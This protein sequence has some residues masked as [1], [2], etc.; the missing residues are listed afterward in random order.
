MTPT[1]PVADLDTRFSSE[2]AHATPWSEVADL[3]ESAEIYWLSTVRP[4]GRP[5][6][7]PLIAVWNDGALYFCTGPTER[8]AK[9]LVQ[10]TGCAVTTGCNRFAEGLDVT[11]EGRAVEI[12]DESRLQQ[13]ADAYAAKYDW[14]FAVRDGTFHSDDGGRALVFEVRPETVFAFGKGDPFSQTR[15]RFPR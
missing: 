13:L 9:N 8:K 14:H 2:T 15:Y 7:T 3:L 11:V 6:V 10:N 1:E 5:H 4:D 12:N